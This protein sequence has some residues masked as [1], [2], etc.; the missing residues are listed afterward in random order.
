[1]L[2]SKYNMNSEKSKGRVINGK[3]TSNQKFNLRLELGGGSQYRHSR[4]S[5]VSL[6]LFAFLIRLLPVQTWKVMQAICIYILLS[7]LLKGLHSI[8]REKMENNNLRVS[9]YD[10][11]IILT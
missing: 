9:F 1:M 5:P 7:H 6:I 11:K 10:F 3:V 4:K 2:K 8:L